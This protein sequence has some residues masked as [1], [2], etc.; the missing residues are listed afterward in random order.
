MFKSYQRCGVQVDFNWKK[1][2]LLILHFD[3][4]CETKFAQNGSENLFYIQEYQ[5][6]FLLDEILYGGK[7]NEFEMAIAIF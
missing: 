5:N 2:G 7:Q 1:V 3:L 4:Y 6:F